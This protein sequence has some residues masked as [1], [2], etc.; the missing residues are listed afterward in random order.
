[1]RL[2]IKKKYVHYIM[3]C[4]KC[5]KCG[6]S[7]HQKSN[8]LIHQL[9][10]YE[11][12][13]PSVE[14]HHAILH[15]TPPSD[16]ISTICVEN[17]TVDFEGPP[18]EKS[19]EKPDFTPKIVHATTLALKNLESGINE[20]T[21]ECY[22]CRKKYKNRRSLVRHVKTCKML[23]KFN[24]SVAN[25][26]KGALVPSEKKTINNNMTTINNNQT[27]NNKN[28]QNIIYVDNR[29]CSDTKLK[30]FGKENL[31]FLT[32]DFL[33]SVIIEPEEGILRLIEKVHFNKD[34]P[35]NQNIQFK[36]KKEPYIDIFN[37]KKWEKQDKKTAIQ[38]IITTKKDIMDDFVDEY[39]ETKLINKFVKENYDTFSKM[40][41]EYIMHTLDS[42][43]ERVKSRVLIKCMS[44]YKEICK[45]A[46][47]LLINNKKN[48]N[49]NSNATT[50]EN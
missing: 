13:D 34:V 37:G 5:S 39:D 18:A 6:K 15:D 20:T 24:I 3:V 4:Y 8:F 11:C 25:S 1:M 22:H 36:N 41:N 7:F 44:F 21:L 40:L 28:T 50:I 17:G 43:D 48:A 49:L 16:Q 33:Q 10:K 29:T 27:T 38:N 9:R 42:Y 47:L 23:E 19:S 14:N 31:G 46:E 35:E 2:V 32:E 45:Q 26:Q 30:P 12:N